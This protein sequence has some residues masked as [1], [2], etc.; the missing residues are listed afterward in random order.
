MMKK[1]VR[2]TLAMALMTGCGGTGFLDRTTPA[3][4]NG[5]TPVGTSTA[6]LAVD[7]RVK[8]TGAA[9]YSNV[10]LAPAAVRAWADGREIP[11]ERVGELVNL[12]AVNH[13]EKIATVQVPADAKLIEFEITL[14]PAGGFE[15]TTASG[16]INTGSKVLRFRSEFANLAE[17]N[18]AVVEINAAKSLVAQDETTL[19]FVPRFRVMY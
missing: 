6:A 12:A 15:S 7:L 4:Q 19:A 9:D 5:E 10:L 2:A 13:A 8:G 18:K 16:W 14:A 3:Q 17:K 11:A 1:M